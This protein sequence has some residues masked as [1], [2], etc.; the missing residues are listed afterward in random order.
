MK[1]NVTIPFFSATHLQIFCD[2]CY[3][4]QRP[5]SDIDNI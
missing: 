4:D 5:R 2:K 3:I 1:G